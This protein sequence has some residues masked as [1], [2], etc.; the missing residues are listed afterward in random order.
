MRFVNHWAYLALNVRQ[1]GSFQLENAIFV[2]EEKSVKRYQGHGTEI[3]TKKGMID[4]MIEK[5]N[6]LFIE[7][8]KI[9]NS[10][11][12]ASKKAK[13]LKKEFPLIRKKNKMGKY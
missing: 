12:S 8:N 10:R 13:K 6:I 11:F 3:L 2:D 9:L 1:T 5:Y 7:V 4:K